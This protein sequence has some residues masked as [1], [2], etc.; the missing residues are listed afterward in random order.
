M[1]LP[2]ARNIVELRQLLAERF[3]GVRMSAERPESISQSCVTGIP[4]IDSLLHG[5]LPKG[6]ITEITSAGLSSGS[7]LFLGSVLQEAQRRGDWLAIVDAA[8]SF[9]PAGLDPE[10]LSRLLWVRS[11][12]VK[13]AIKATDLLLHDG[14]ISVV[15]LDLVFCA[16]NQLRKIPSSTWFRLQRIL[17]YN[18]TALVVLAPEHLISNAQARLALE[19]RFNLESMDQPREVLQAR[20]APVVPEIAG[21]HIV[22]RIA[23]IA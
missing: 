20:I 18:S 14:T 8:D 13:D 5:G 15:A 22:K 3:P 10:A 4:Q 19:K 1:S 17:D 16:H 12:S 7:L 23:K 9:D 2:N 11:S 21:R 6:G